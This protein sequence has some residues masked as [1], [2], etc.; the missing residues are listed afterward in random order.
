MKWAPMTENAK[1][2]ADNELG[3]ARL[4]RSGM[5]STVLAADAGLP[6]GRLR[7]D[8]RVAKR[9]GMREQ[10]LDWNIV[11]LPPDGE[12]DAPEPKSTP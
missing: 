11:T 3:D 4:P 10:H 5:R 1:P 9:S 8:A 7:E 12:I 6:T 2:L